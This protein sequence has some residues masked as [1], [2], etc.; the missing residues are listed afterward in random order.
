MTLQRYKSKRS[1]GDTPEPGGGTPHGEALHFVIQKH[2]ASHLHYDFRLEMAGV[3]KS[4]A[5][6]KGPSTDPSVRRLAMMVEDHPYD[7]KDFEGIIPE[8]NYGAGTVMVWDEGT[9]EPIDGTEGRKAMER[10]LLKQ[11]KEGSLKFTLQGSKLKGEYALVRT[12][13]MGDNA[14]LLIKHKDRYARTSDVT[15]KDT[16]VKSGRTLAGIRRASPNGAA[17][18]KAETPAKK[19]AGKV[20]SKAASKKRTAGFSKKSRAKPQ[21]KAVAGTSRSAGSPDD[22]RDGPEVALSALVGKAPKKKR[23]VQ[24]EP[25]LATLVDEPF[26]E[27]GWLFEIKWDG[28]R[29]VSFLGKGKAHITSRNQK[30]FDEKFYPVHEA[31]GRWNIPAVVDGEI[32]VVNEQGVSDF[33]ALQNWRSEADGVIRY[34]LFDILWYDGRDLTSLPL[35]ERRSVLEAVMPAGEPLIQFSES[36]D[37]SAVEFL[38]AAR[39]LGLEGI[40]AKRKDSL[41]H[42]GER[43]RDWLKI[44]ASRRQEVVIGGYTRNAGT[45]KPFSSLLVGVFDKADFVYAGKIGTGFNHEMQKEMLRQ[46]RPL[47]VKSSPFAVSPDVNK[48]SR[49]RPDPPHASAVWLKPELVCEVSYTERTRDGV[50]R[51][52]SFKGMREDKD[53]R[54]VVLEK[55]KKAT[56]VIR[57]EKKQPSSPGVARAKSPAPRK[58][59]VVPRP[60]GKAARGTLLNPS[61]ETQVREVDGHQMT[62]THLSKVFWPGEKLTKRDMINYYYQV[63]PVM[64]PYLEGRPQSLNR[65]PNGIKGK[66]FYQK[67]VTGKVPAWIR[68]FLYHAEDDP[69]DKHFLVA[70]ATASLLYMASLGCIE[71]NPWSSTVKK[72]DKPTWC[73]IDLDPGSKTTFDQVI[74]AAHITREVLESLKVPSYPKTS[75]ATGM[76]IYIPLGGKYTFEQSREFARVV[77]TLVH[78]RAGNFTSLERSVSARRGKMY[79]DF[80]QNRQQAT[81][82]APYSLRP[83]PGATVSMPLAWEEVTAGLKPGDFTIFN[84]IDRLRSAG[85]LFKPVLGKGIS[86]SGVLREAEKSSG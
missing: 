68:T 73:I 11:L 53:A 75:G 20:A 44:K 79:L 21:A 32:V 33:G 50:M 5:V 13:G 39:K 19:R 24:V 57:K 36:Y 55:E 6:P 80:L 26:E 8:G 42:A 74:E 30:S 28:Y 63:A 10:S 17:Q 70:E 60:P 65:F 86:L 16:S 35:T 69:E 9:Y 52:P 3:L 78:D 45:A 48:P 56:E 58:K 71:I 76:H 64:L 14:W 82:A 37:V 72:P 22:D 23:P 83:R 38:E 59:K 12:R 27:P 41:Y 54:E 62:F 25:M 61:E 77:V 67:D 1:L 43:S 4:W 47:V 40:M 15:N 46:F 18:K 49:F 29:A 66:H 84:A 2:D 34:Y 85:D 81:V 31:L 51:H 7:Y